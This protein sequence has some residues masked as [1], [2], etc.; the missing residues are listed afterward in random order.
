MEE[1]ESG[2]PALSK[3]LRFLPFLSPREALVSFFEVRH[4][5]ALGLWA[6]IETN[7]AGWRRLLE[8]VVS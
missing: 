8:S 2:A 7:G 4:I 1:G 5:I 6:K 3:A